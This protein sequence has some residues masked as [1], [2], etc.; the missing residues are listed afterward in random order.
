MRPF[1]IC[2]RAILEEKLKPSTLD[3]SLKIIDLRLQVHLTGA[4]E[5]TDL[6]RTFGII[7]VHVRRVLKTLLTVYIHSCFHLHP[8]ICREFYEPGAIMLEEEA[9]VIGG[10]LVGLN[11]IDCNLGIKDEDLDQPVSAVGREQNGRHF[12]EIF[13]SLFLNEKF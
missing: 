1:G 12:A 11:V 5:L 4:N 13:I 7:V 3:N 8:F 10:L 2:L 6:V 9:A